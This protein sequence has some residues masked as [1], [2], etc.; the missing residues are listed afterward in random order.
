MK[1]IQEKDKVKERVGF[2][3]A[4]IEIVREVTHK[5]WWREERELKWAKTSSG[6][7][8]LSTLIDNSDRTLNVIDKT[9]LDWDK[10]TKDAKLE[11]ELD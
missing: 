1:K 11:K 8:E 9:K 7:D 6:L 5:D 2:A 3:G 4:K 10:H